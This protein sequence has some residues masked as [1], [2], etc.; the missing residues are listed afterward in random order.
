MGARILGQFVDLP[1]DFPIILDVD[2][3]AE[4]EEDNNLI[5]WVDPETT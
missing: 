5:W 1:E 3:K 4:K 2:V